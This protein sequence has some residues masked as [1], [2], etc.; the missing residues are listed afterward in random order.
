MGGGGEFPSVWLSGQVE[1]ALWLCRVRG[2][3]PRA[4]RRRAIEEAAEILRRHG[5]GPKSA[6]RTCRQLRVAARDAA[7]FVAAQRRVLP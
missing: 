2:G 1:R 6:C 4:V 5:I 7:R 3:I